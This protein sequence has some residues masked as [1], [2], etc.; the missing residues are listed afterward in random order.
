MKYELVFS[1]KFRKKIS[2]LD[3]KSQILILRKI[4]ILG[5]NP[6]AGKSLKSSSKRLRSLRIGKYRVIY[7]VN[8]KIFILAV[9]HRKDIYRFVV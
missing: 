2:K 7:K 4:K 1:K 8:Q 3:K 5:D 6:S 9:G